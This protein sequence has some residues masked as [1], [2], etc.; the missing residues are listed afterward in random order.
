MRVI[1][2]LKLFA[3]LKVSLVFGSIGRRKFISH[4]RK[5]KL[6]SFQQSCPAESK[7][8]FTNFVP[9]WKGQFSKFG[10]PS[11]FVDFSR[12]FN[13]LPTNNPMWVKPPYV[14]GLPTP[15]L[16]CNEPLIYI[17]C[18][19]D[20]IDK[21]PHSKPHSLLQTPSNSDP[22][23]ADSDV[24]IVLADELTSVA[25]GMDLQNMLAAPSPAGCVDD[26]VLSNSMMMPQVS[27]S[28]SS[29]TAY[30]YSDMSINPGAH[31]GELC[32]KFTSQQAV[33]TAEQ[34]STD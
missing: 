7:V 20:D 4:S 28:M 34:T 22:A 9:S 12:D 2:K 31:I 23:K 21:T 5:M 6:Q 15:I 27:M 32:L 30:P 10:R 3:M 29:S 1:F 26:I 24:T 8:K 13:T 33:K 16:P 25:P 17:A 14:P 19:G 11:N 18:M